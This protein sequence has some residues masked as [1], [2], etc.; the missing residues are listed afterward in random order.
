MYVFTLICRLGLVSIAHVLNRFLH[1]RRSLHPP[2]TY[3]SC[4]TKPR[5][6]RTGFSSHFNCPGENR[7]SGT[8]ALR[9]RDLTGLD[10]AGAHANALRI[11]VHQ[12]LYRLQVHVPA[13]PRH[14]VR[15]RNIIAKLRPFAANITYLCHLNLLQTCLQFPHQPELPKAAL[16]RPDSGTSTLRRAKG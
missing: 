8:A 9:L 15:V 5:P 13:P 2:T 1:L 6:A 7:C 3:A 10:A 11:A 16:I 14:I 4:T 12:R